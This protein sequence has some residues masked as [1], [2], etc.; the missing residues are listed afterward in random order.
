MPGT[1]VIAAIGLFAA[2]LWSATSSHAGGVFLDVPMTRVFTCKSVDA[3]MEIYVPQSLMSR[4]DI[5]KTGTGGT[6]NGLYA[7]DLTGAQKGK[8]IEPVRL[9]STKDN[10]AIVMQQFI[11]KGLRPA[12]IAMAGGK[13]DLDPRFGTKAQ[14]EP[15]RAP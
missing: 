11:R 5:E 9:R 4:R 10:K 6:V 2:S 1:Y 8:V 15:F 13:L 12:T 7:L 3:T 14:C